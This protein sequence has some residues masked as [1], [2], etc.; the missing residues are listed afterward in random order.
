MDPQPYVNGYVYSNG[1]LTAGASCVAPVL[2]IS[3]WLPETLRVSWLNRT[4]F[5]DSLLTSSQPL[6]E[7]YFWNHTE[8]HAGQLALVSNFFPSSGFYR[9]L[10]RLE[11]LAGGVDFYI[12][13]FS[14]EAGYY[15]AKVLDTCAKTTCC[16]SEASK[17]SLCPPYSKSLEESTSYSPIFAGSLQ[18]KWK[19]CVIF[20]IAVRAIPP[21]NGLSSGVSCI[22]PTTS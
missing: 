4:F 5:E 19:S 2:E 17:L 9:S 3:N 10:L 8:V 14:A 18:P 16:P 20:P 11:S 15:F 12:F 7:Q 13:N 21:V 22:L 6:S 1:Q